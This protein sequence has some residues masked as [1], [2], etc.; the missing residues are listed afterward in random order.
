VRTKSWTRSGCYTHGH[1]REARFRAAASSSAMVRHCGQ[2]D[3]SALKNDIIFAVNRG[4]LARSAGLP[5]PTF[6]VISDLRTYRANTAEIRAADVG[7]RFY[8]SKVAR[9]REYQGTNDREFAIPFE[10]DKRRLMHQGHFSDDVFQGTARG[11]TVVLDAVQIATHLGFREIYVIGVDLSAPRTGPTHFY[12]SGE[13][14]QAR[15]GDMNVD[16]VIKGFA[17]ARE[18]LEA[19]GGSLRNAGLGGN[20]T[21]LERVSFSSLFE[22]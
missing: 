18:Y 1:H 16:E 17:V 7:L 8:R 19:L 5:K 22:V 3:L 9:S 15:L 12:G 20:L 10:F 6:H 11:K 2:H 4:Y 14:E 13:H 21:T